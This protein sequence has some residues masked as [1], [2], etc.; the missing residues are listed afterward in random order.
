MFSVGFQRFQIY[1]Y[2][3]RQTKTRG[4]PEEI[5]AVPRYKKPGHRFL[6]VAQSRLPKI[7]HFAGGG[8]NFWKFISIYNCLL[9]PVK[10]DLFGPEFLQRR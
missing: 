10:V 9:N 1:L 7:G 8:G 6:Q 5:R 4:P 2:G 3:P